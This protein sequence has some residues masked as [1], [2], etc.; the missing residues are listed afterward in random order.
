MNN[1]NGVQSSRLS[2]RLEAYDGEIGWLP[3][4]R[5]LREDR[6][7]SVAFYN[8]LLILTRERKGYDVPQVLK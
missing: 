1:F 5:S 3:L 6:F 8:F 7:D 4:N 2:D